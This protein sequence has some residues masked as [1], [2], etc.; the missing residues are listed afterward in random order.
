MKKDITVGIIGAGKW[1]KNL[2]REFDKI[3]YI[4]TCAITKNS[5][6]KEWVKENY[7]H[8]KITNT[9]KN[10]LSDPN[11]TAVVI[12]TPIKTHYKIAKN[13]LLAGKNIFVEKTLT[14]NN[15]QA[16]ELSKIAKKKKLTIFVGHIFLYH[17]IFTKIKKI[18]TKEK[19]KYIEFNWNKF[20]TFDENIYLNLLSH[21]IALALKL[22]GKINHIQ[23]G[24]IQK[25]I[26]SKDIIH[27]KAASRNK[28]NCTFHINRVSD[29]KSK[30][31]TITTN[32]NIYIWRDDYLYKLNKERN[33]FTEICRSKKTALEIEC[34]EFI[35]HTKLNTRPM[36]DGDFGAQVLEI[37]EK[38]NS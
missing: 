27:I 38:I 23:P 15:F 4:S 11:I 37:I 30:S 5:K 18:L 2:I 14:S 10:I 33:G 16:Q 21:D 34:E 6:N 22:L 28:T 25:A 1:G 7:S 12:A 20:G 32:K 19:L 29:K 31:V 17:Q 35:R 36:A 26:T 13:A 3:S 9:Y 24:H 8:I